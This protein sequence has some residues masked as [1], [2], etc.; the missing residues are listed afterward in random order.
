ML[1]LIGVS[2]LVREQEKEMTILITIYTQIHKATQF[3]TQKYR[4]PPIEELGKTT[5]MEQLLEKIQQ[6]TNQR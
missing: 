5:T 2:K 6:S 4:L 1:G 3:L